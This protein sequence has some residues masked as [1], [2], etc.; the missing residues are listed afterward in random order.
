[1]VEDLGGNTDRGERVAQ[2]VGEHRQ[3]L[4]L[5]AM[6]FGQPIGALPELGL[7]L[8]ALGDITHPL[9]ANFL[10]NLHPCLSWAGTS[11]PIPMFFGKPVTRVLVGK[12]SFSP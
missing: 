12:P 9:P 7:E 6:L 5:A 10:G 1:T 11:R 2:L 3:K 4:V 8:L